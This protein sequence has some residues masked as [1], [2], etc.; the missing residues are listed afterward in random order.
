MLFTA[1]QFDASEL[2]ESRTDLEYWK[3]NALAFESENRD[4]RKRLHLQM[5]ESGALERKLDGL[6]QL[7]H[8]TLAEN[9]QLRGQL[10]EQERK[11]E[12]Q[13]H[14]QKIL[15]RRLADQQKQISTLS[16][17]LSKEQAYAK[18]RRATLREQITELKDKLHTLT[19]REVALQLDKAIV[20]FVRPGQPF[21]YKLARLVDDQGKLG[22]DE[23]HRL[24]Q[25]L[26]VV[27]AKQDAKE[28]WDLDTI[29]VVMDSLKDA[30]VVIAH[31]ADTK[32]SEDL[33]RSLEARVEQSAGKGAG[34]AY[35]RI[36]TLL[37][38][39]RKNAKQDLFVYDGQLAK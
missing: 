5:R 29:R 24:H 32:I 38:A 25:V 36:V 30:G 4:L 31:A 21:H 11:L 35:Q 39:L 34:K 9:R 18:A 7:C 19:V 37:K 33:L 22:E 1:V 2:D 3:S 26:A 27:N 20:E 15:E 16:K 28:K 8:K 6:R 23:T 10:S 14:K 13:E 12:I 17:D